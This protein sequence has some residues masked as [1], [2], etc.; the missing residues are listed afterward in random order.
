MGEKPKKPQT[1]GEWLWEK[2]KKLL[3][4]LITVVLWVL[5]T[6]ITIALI[7]LLVYWWAIIVVVIVLGTTFTAIATEGVGAVL[8]VPA[9]IVIVILALILI[10]LCALVMYGWSFMERTIRKYHC[11][12]L[13]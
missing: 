13:G 10:V 4:G 1:W 12:W 7:C 9:A 5:V 8:T 2:G 6:V 11:T 3:C